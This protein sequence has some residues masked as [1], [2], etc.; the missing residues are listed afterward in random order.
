[1]T[2]TV[3][4]LQAFAGQRSASGSAAD[5]EP[6]TAQ[7]ARGPDQI[8]DTLESE[9]RIVNKKRDR[10]DPVVGVS[11]TGGDKRTHRSRFGN[12]FFQNLSVFSFLV[13]EQSG[14]VYRLIELAY[15]GIDSYL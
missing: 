5:Q 14:H 4:V 11:R 1:M 8:A 9:H 2:V 12:A 6:T 15:A 13:I 10:I 3:L 7:I